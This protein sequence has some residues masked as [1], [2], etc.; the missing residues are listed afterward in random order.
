MAPAPLYVATNDYLTRSDF[1]A[2]SATMA[3]GEDVVR[4]T[5]A[6]G[7]RE[8]YNQ[9]AEANEAV[10]DFND[11]TMLLLHVDGQPDKQVT[12]VKSPI[13]GFEVDIRGIDAKRVPHVVS[14]FRCSSSTLTFNGLR[15][16]PPSSRHFHRVALI[17]AL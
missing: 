11:Y 12:L 16:A 9:I 13:S 14:R 15:A 1:V 5:L 7:G 8:K 10:V 3:Y 4:A 2:A 17:D 6:P